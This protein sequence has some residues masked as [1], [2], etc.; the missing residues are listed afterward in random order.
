V[1]VHGFTQTAES[2][3]PLVAALAGEREVRAL[4]APGHGTQAGVR[5]DLWTG[6]DLL[7]EAGGAATYVGYSMGARFCL[8]AA[9]AHPE[10]VRGLVLVSGT[11]G[12]ESEDER[13]ARRT[14]DA[15]LADRLRTEG[16]AR[17]LDRWLAQPMFAGLSADA[18]GRAARLAN[19][20]EGLASSLERAGTGTQEP[21]W[22]R[23]AELAM[24]V[25]VVAGGRDAKFAALAERLAAGIGPN[26]DLVVVPEAG[27]TVH[28]E[29]AAAFLDVLQEWL[30]RHGL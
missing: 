13:L 17:F 22:D 9:L 7:A 25:L 10:A 14:A 19:T 20:A 24:P 18:A 27:H 11:A 26:A 3:A 8:H 4:D 30:T 2:W 5:A 12:L 28:L 1:L 15:A 29:Q 23:L 16:V 21:L 6:A